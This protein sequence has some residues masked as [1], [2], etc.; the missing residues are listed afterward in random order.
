MTPFAPDADAADAGALSLGPADCRDVNRWWTIARS[1][2]NV[3]HELKNALQVIS[4]NVEMMQLRTDLDEVTERRLR[5]IAAQAVRAVDT[6]AP[7]LAYAR[8]SASA[9]DTVDLRALA[10][11]AL[12]FRSVSLGRGGVTTSVAPSNGEPQFA[13]IDPSSALQT[14]LNLLLQA[15]GEVFGRA[16][17]SITVSVDRQGE[18]VVA[19]IEGRAQGIRPDTA[20][21]SAFAYA[22]SARVA[23][24]LAQACGAMLQVERNPDQ[25][26]LALSVPADTSSLQ[27]ADSAPLSR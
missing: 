15:E 24:E 18:V 27:A 22:L 19:V 9:P 11:V 17:A 8:G 7:L 4:G 1:V 3:A 21:E 16:E 2:S 25:I 6:M 26:R 12:S 13:R 23:N 14:L 20:G 5:S 10:A